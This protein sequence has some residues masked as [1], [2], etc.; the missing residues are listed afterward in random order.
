MSKLDIAGKILDLACILAAW[1]LV[2]KGFEFLDHD[3]T[4]S[5]FYVLAA[6]Y[7]RVK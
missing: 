2:V 3:P 4:K 6:I 5:I 1:W 7:M